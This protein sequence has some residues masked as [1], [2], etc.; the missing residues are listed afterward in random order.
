M[1]WAL[2]GAWMGVIFYWSSQMNPAIPG[3]G[4]DPFRKSLHVLEYMLLFALWQRALKS[5][6]GGDPVVTAMWALLLTA[7]YAISD[8]IHQH[9]VGR[10]GSVRDVLIDTALP[11][12]LS[13]TLWVRRRMARRI[14]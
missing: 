4:F 12:L 5:R 3:I 8:E 10:D 11:V 2:L 1:D 9:V 14:R 6:V 7:G 13:V